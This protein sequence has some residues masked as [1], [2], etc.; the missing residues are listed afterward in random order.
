MNPLTEIPFLFIVGR[1]RSGTTLLRT[2]FDAHTNVVMP[3]ECQFVVNLYGKYGKK[4]NWSKKDLKQFYDDLLIQWRFKSW[5]MDN[6]QLMENLLKNEGPNSYGNICKTVYSTYQSVFPKEK[7]LLFGDKNPGYAIYTRRLLKIFPNARFIH[8]IRDYRD[9]FVSVKNVDF[10]LSIPSS[11]GLKWVYFYQKVHRDARKNPSA[12]YHIRYEDLVSEPEKTLKSLCEFAG[13]EYQP[14]ILNFHDKKDDMLKVYSP[15]V[16][17]TYH[18]SLFKK[19]NTS[20][21]GLWEKQLTDDEV[22]LLDYTIGPLAEQAG[23]KRKY[24]QFNTVIALKAIPGKSIATFLRTATRI[25]DKLPASIRMNILSKGP[26]A[27]ATAYLKLFNPKK[28]EQIKKK[29]EE[30]HN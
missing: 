15:A 6:Q 16:M 30:N 12:Y 2:L 22:K 7:I 5:K 14:E 1:P 9:N 27:I 17:N 29:I 26:L 8:I 25:V 10:E 23:Y 24:T 13:I 4:S 19:I 28:L 3:P 18:A 21:I 20:R 11:V